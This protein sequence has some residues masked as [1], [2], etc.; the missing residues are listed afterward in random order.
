MEETIVEEKK[1]NNKLTK[2]NYLFIFLFYGFVVATIPIIITELSWDG[3]LNGIGVEKNIQRELIECFLRAA[4]LE[5]TFKFIAFLL[6]RKKFKINIIAQS[7]FAA[8]F[9]GLMYAIIEKAVL[10]NPLAIVINL[11]FPMHLLW[12]WNQ[13]RHYQLS[14]DA[15]KNNRKGKA[16]FHMFLATFMVFFLH[17]TWDALLSIA[18]YFMDSENAIANGELYGGIVIGVT[19][20][21]GMIYTI[22]TFIITFKTSKKAKKENKETNQ[23]VEEKQ[24]IKE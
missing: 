6:A 22:V 3:I 5:E 7:M 2:K 11:F 18:G 1:E 14:K 9:I 23:E 13:G 17:G 19:L 8:G 16:F 10:F 24:N 4:L 12:Q 21:L 20:F 15:K